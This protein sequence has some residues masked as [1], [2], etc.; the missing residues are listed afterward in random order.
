MTSLRFTDVDSGNSTITYRRPDGTFRTL[1]LLDAPGQ[2]TNE[3]AAAAF[4]NLIQKTD[5]D[6]E[7]NLSDLPVDD[8]EHRDNFQNLNAAKE[9]FAALY[10]NKVFI[11]TRPPG[12]QFWRITRIEVVRITWDAVNSVYNVKVSINV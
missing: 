5:I 8:P 6:A 9:F 1:T 10:G 7:V 3:D 12:N 2:D 4:Q 11:E